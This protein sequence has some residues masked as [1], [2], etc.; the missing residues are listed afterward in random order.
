MLKQQHQASAR[1]WFEDIKPVIPQD[2]GAPNCNPL[3][4]TRFT[5]GLTPLPLTSRPLS[6][7]P[8]R[9]LVPL[10]SRPSTGATLVG[11]MRVVLVLADGVSWHEYPDCALLGAGRTTDG[12]GQGRGRSTVWAMLLSQEQRVRLVCGCLMWCLK[13]SCSFQRQCFTMFYLL[14]PRYS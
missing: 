14:A 3:Q 6:F 11:T 13:K 10:H 9:S 12:D 7:T 4:L 8:F 5:C 2:L 1:I